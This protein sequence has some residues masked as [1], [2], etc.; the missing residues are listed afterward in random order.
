MFKNEY[1]GLA[2]PSTEA[3]ERALP[4]CGASICSSDD[5]ELS[6]EALILMGFAKSF[7]LRGWDLIL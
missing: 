4:P 3:I 5:E 1:Q 2:S 7:P 6:S